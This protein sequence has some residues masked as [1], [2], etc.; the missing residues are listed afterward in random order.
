MNRAK[1][2][3]MSVATSSQA[4]RSAIV[5]LIGEEGA[6]IIDTLKSSATVVTGKDKGKEMKTDIIKVATKIALMAQNRQ[7]TQTDAPRFEEAV[8]A[9][10]DG[11]LLL[12]ELATKNDAE[13]QSPAA[14]SST[15][16]VSVQSKFMADC[17]SA[18]LPVVQPFMQERNWKKFSAVFEYFGSE[19]FLRGFITSPQLAQERGEMLRALQ[20]MLRPY[21]TKDSETLLKLRR[22]RARKAELLVHHPSLQDW[23]VTEDARGY[24]QYF[25]SDLGGKV[26]A[27]ET[28]PI[29]LLQFWLAIEGY[30]QVLAIGNGLVSSVS[31]A[32]RP[33]PLSRERTAAA[34][35]HSTATH[36]G[37]RPRPPAHSPT[38]PSTRPPNLRT[39]ARLPPDRVASFPPRT[40]PCPPPPSFQ[41]SAR[42]LLLSRAKALVDK[43]LAA[44][45]KPEERVAVPAEVGACP[46]PRAPAALLRAP[47]CRHLVT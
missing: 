17:H 40:R 7:V 5:K 35:T 22:Q 9:N 16:D 14:A 18:L 19:S 37:A 46:P 45:V 31:T 36:T 12:L 11:M 38:H 10:A 41:I 44:R 39:P 8:L 15:I 32:A 4:G 43:Y 28:R 25:L 26:P 29:V 6:L 33:R 13:A 24:L 47:S 21:E 3:M 2:K 27:G 30:K 42:G 23:L 34:A 1:K 20:L